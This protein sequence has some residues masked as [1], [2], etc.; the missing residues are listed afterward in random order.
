MEITF[1]FLEFFFDSLSDSQFSIDSQEPR[2]S[3]RSLTVSDFKDDLKSVTTNPA[4]EKT[5]SEAAEVAGVISQRNSNSEIVV[6]EYATN[7]MNPQGLLLYVEGEASFYK[8]SS[9]AMESPCEFGGI[10]SIYVLQTQF[11]RSLNP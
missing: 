11:H 5:L 8:Q 10:L 7:S 2:R 1:L 9:P 6:F 4:L 3:T